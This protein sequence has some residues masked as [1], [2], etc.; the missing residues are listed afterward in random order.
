MTVDERAGRR[1]WV[2][3]AAL[4]LPVVLVAM[5]LSVLYL[6]LPTLARELAPTAGETLWILDVYGFLLAGLLITMGGLGDRI[7][8]RRLL[9][10]GASL[11]GVASVLAAF[12]TTPAMLIA[13]RAL[14][15]VGGSTLMPST[16][17]LIRSMFADDTQRASAIGIWTAGFAGGSLVGPIVGGVLLQYFD[18]G[19]VFLINVPVLVVLLVSVP[20]LVPEYRDPCPGRFDLVSVVLSLAAILPV[21]YGIKHAAA[22][23]RVDLTT[24]LTIGAGIAVGVAFVRRQRG[25]EAPMLDPVLLRDRRFAGAVGGGAAAMFAMVGTN[26]YTVQ[27]LQQV[28]G[29]DPLLAALWGI[30]PMVLV[31]VGAV[32]APRLA[33]RASTRTALLVGFLLAAAGSALLVLTPARDGLAVIVGSGVVLALGLSIVLTLATDLVVTAAPPDRAGAASAIS[34]TGTEFGA[35]AGIAVM[36][37]IGAAVYR[38]AAE[39]RLPG[40]L[41]AEAAQLAASTLP[42]AQQLAHSLPPALAAQVV[43]AGREAFTLGL[44][45][46]AGVG[47]VCL[48]LLAVVVPRL[49]GEPSPRPAG[50]PT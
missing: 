27:Y 4:V 22:G 8:R 2:G 39:E 18:W 12:S 23:G 21:V 24:A 41:P 26:F 1:E 45:T 16:L 10:I 7:G 11:F 47:A 15:G 49:V 17:S 30:P 14:M 31:A 36:G 46:V 44:V 40:G 38:A 35:A 13:A 37:S 29:F 5:D 50:R 32:L 42:N 6:A 19:A 43:A 28:L 3:L 48:G 9:L 25:L 34:E 33:R 20:L